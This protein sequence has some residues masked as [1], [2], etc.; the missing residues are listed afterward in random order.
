MSYCKTEG[1]DGKD[2]VIFLTE[3]DATK[4]STVELP[5]TKPADAPQ[6]LITESGEINWECPCLGG[7]AVGPCGVEFREA[8]S[9]FHYSKEEPKGVECMEAFSAMQD[10]MKDYP[11]LYAKENEAS[12]DMSETNLDEKVPYQDSESENKDIS[13]SNSSKVSDPSADAPISETSVTN[14]SEVSNAPVIA[15]DPTSNDKQF[16]NVISSDKELLSESGLADDNL[17]SES[18]R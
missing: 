2:K 13:E 8:F 9:C 5:D 7:M 4:P 3:E 12:A 17:V 15:V 1:S 6:G 11:E 16:S 18:I 14:N 10:C